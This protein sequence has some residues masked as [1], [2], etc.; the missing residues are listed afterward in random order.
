MT[1][2]RYD[3]HTQ[4]AQERFDKKYIKT[5]MGCWQWQSPVDA[6]GYGSF[7]LNF[8]GKKYAL[9]AHR[10]SW[11][12]S[13]KQDW[14]T[15]KPVARHVCNNPSCVNPEHI[16]PGTV[17]ENAAD[18]IAAGTH[19]RGTNARKRAV[20]TPIGEFESGAA[21]ARALG[22][23]HPHL[24]QLLKTHNDYCYKETQ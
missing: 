14:P 5:D 6:D 2:Y 12:M 15:D 22:I 7:T 17:K 9:R 20:K 8:D 3:Q 18:A 11:I 16:M 4:S 23:R 13:N 1:Y 19:Y 24:I 21:A 10:Y